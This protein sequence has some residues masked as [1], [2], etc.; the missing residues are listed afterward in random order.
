MLST[1]RGD[2]LSVSSGSHVCSKE[3]IAYI[4]RA[5]ESRGYRGQLEK[6]REACGDHLLVPAKCLLHSSP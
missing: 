3:Y 5:E 4:Q 1:W 6:L 2:W